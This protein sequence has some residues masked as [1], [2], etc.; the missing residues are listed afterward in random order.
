VPMQ[1]CHVCKSSADAKWLHGKDQGGNVLP[2]KNVHLEELL[3]CYYKQYVL[4]STR[5]IIAIEAVEVTENERAFIIMQVRRQQLLTCWSGIR[6]NMFEPLS[7]HSS[8]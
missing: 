4:G 2:Y 3:C 6:A 1:S 8:F 7:G 5:A